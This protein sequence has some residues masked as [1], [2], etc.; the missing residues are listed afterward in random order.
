MIKKLPILI[1]VFIVGCA[2]PKAPPVLD[3]PARPELKQYASPPIIRKI[4]NNFEVT[5]DLILNSTLLTD[6]YKRI[7]SWKLNNNVR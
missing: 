7:E 3:F 4:E 1:M 6:Y 5:G 2:S